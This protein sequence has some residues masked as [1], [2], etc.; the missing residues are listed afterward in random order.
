MAPRFPGVFRDFGGAGEAAQGRG[1]AQTSP[2]PPPPPTWLWAWQP[3]KYVSLRVSWSE[4]GGPVLRFSLQAKVITA[5]E[6]A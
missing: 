4:S 5:L 6:T 3:W 1:W 2:P